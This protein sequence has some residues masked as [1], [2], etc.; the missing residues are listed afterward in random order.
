MVFKRRD[1]KPTLRALWEFFWP[2]GGWG[3]AARYVKHRL[4]RLP[5]PPE[6]I[7]RGIWAGVFTTFT[8]FYT[9]HFLVAAFLAF[10]MRGNILAALLGTFFGNPLT[11]VPIAVISLQTGYFLLGHEFSPHIERTLTGKFVDA[12]EDLTRNFW[13]WVKGQPPDW[14]GLEVFWDDVFYPYMIGGIIPGIVAATAAYLV[15]EPLIRAYQARRKGALKKR[16]EAI[17]AKAAAKKAAAAEEARE[18]AD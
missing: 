3:R 18:K 7:A 6:K 10:I 8:P 17:R 16:L 1:R 9:L 4:R 2:R 14:H 12:G 13:A 15:A 5:D 11:Y